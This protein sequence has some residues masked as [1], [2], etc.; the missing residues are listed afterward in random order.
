[1]KCKDCEW[2]V[3]GLRRIAYRETI[4]V[5][6][7]MVTRKRCYPNRECVAPSEKKE[8]YKKMVADRKNE[9]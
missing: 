7:C 4:K 3:P 2:M 9:R 6:L 8:Q 1:M 5:K